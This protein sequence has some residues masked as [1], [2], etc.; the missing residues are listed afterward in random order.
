M[1]NRR[2]S[3]KWICLTMLQSKSKR[4][5][6]NL[7]GLVPLI[8]SGALTLY[9]NSSL[10]ALSKFTK[11]RSLIIDHNNITNFKS[12]PFCPD[13]ETL[14]LAHNSVRDMNWALTLISERYPQLKHLNMIKNPMNPMFGSESKKYDEFRAT[15]QIWLPSLMTLDGID[16]KKDKAKISEISE[17][18][19]TE[20]ARIMHYVGGT[21]VSPQEETKSGA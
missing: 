15:V 20:K 16:F 9:C 11:L 13:L 12:F 6:T 19:K 2:L 8:L 1:L 18:V 14:S 10:A 7:S 3:S 4:T 21:D 17:R 5:I